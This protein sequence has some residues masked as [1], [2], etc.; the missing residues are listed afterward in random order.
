MARTGNAVLWAVF[1]TVQAI[2]VCLIALMVFAFASA[3]IMAVAFVGWLPV[4]AITGRTEMPFLIW[5]TSGAG[6]DAIGF[7]IWYGVRY[8]QREER[9]KQEFIARSKAKPQETSRTRS[10]YMN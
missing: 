7:C 10:R 4:M 6:V 1:V 5:F 3:F 2:L 9:R 8:L